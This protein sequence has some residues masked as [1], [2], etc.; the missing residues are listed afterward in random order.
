MASCCVTGGADGGP[1]NVPFAL[2]YILLEGED[3]QRLFGAIP[4]EDVEQVGLTRLQGPAGH[5]QVVIAQRNRLCLLAL[6]VKHVD[7]GLMQRSGL[8]KIR[9]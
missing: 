3:F 9:Q 6:V 7:G 5:L 4:T 1:L 8:M 2:R